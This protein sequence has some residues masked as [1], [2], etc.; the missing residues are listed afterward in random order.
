MS[1]HHLMFT[2][3]RAAVVLALAS[4]FF[5]SNLRAA[6]PKK[7]WCFKRWPKAKRATPKQTRTCAKQFLLRAYECTE[8]ELDGRMDYEPGV[9]AAMLLRYTGAQVDRMFDHVSHV[10][11]KKNCDPAKHRMLARAQDLFSSVSNEYWSLRD[12]VEG[13]GAGNPIT[14]ILAKL[15][16]G[17][18]IETPPKGRYSLNALTKLRNAPYA[19]HGRPFRSRDLHAF[20]YHPRKHCKILP[21]KLNS[22]YKDSLLTSVDRTN[23]AVL[24]RLARAARKAVKR[25]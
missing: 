23:V 6:A 21:Q 11:G 15:L 16:A 7:A 12:N 14:A 24:L 19:R 1:Y 8:A 4:T 18:R 22:A 13:G 10:C 20:F 17:E 5:A 25:W 2:L 9:P 3:A